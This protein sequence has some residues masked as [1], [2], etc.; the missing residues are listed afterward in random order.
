MAKVIEFKNPCADARIEIPR[1]A[2]FDDAAR[3]LS[4]YIKDLPLNK[5][6]NDEVIALIVEQVKEAELGAFQFGLRLGLKVFG[7]RA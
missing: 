4:N 5:V 1:T 6:Q 7:G 2:G 3:R